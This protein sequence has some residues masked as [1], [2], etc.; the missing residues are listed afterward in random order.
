MQLPS[1]K[2]GSQLENSSSMHSLDLRV[3]RTWPTVPAWKLPKFMRKTRATP[4]TWNNMK[5][6]LTL[7]QHVQMRGLEIA[8]STSLLSMGTLEQT[9]ANKKGVVFTLNITH[10]CNM[11]ARTFT[12]FF[13]TFFSVCSI[14]LMKILFSAPEIFGQ[15]P[16]S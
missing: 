2:T 4:A 1:Q 14:L 7:H 16:G 10:P 12:I 6:L 15:L 13:A 8:T 3:P 11:F 9:N 5:L